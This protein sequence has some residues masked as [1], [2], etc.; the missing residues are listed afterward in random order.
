MIWPSDLAPE[1]PCSAPTCRHPRSQHADFTGACEA[2]RCLE[3]RSA[4]HDSV[5]TACMRL[6]WMHQPTALID[7]WREKLQAVLPLTAPAHRWE[8]AIG[9]VL[10]QHGIPF[11]LEGEVVRPQGI[12]APNGTSQTVQGHV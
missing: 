8:A 6:I 1:K 4:P 5:L 11:A 10:S 12:L 9:R 2:C 3:W 7:D